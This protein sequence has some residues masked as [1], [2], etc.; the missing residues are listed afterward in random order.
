MRAVL[1]GMRSLELEE[2]LEKYCPD[3]PVNFGTWIRLMIGPENST[4]SESFDILVCTPDWIK[5]QYEIERAIWGRHMLI[6]LE[7]N[8]DLIKTEVNH[9][10]ENCTGSDWGVI[11]QKLSRIGKWEF[12]DYV[13]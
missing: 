3:D 2:P 11:A 10:I 1:K 13:P 6:V 5:V 7:Y 9:Y 12:E 8:F 4:G